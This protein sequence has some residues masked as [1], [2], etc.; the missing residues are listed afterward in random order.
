MTKTLGQLDEAVAGIIAPAGE[1][2]YRARLYATY[3][4]AQR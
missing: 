4:F 1:P 2:T 3:A